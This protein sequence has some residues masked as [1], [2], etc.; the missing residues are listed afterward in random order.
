MS[1]VSPL[2]QTAVAKP[3]LVGDLYQSYVAWCRS[4]GLQPFDM[5]EFGDQ[6]KDATDA[7]GIR[8]R[9]HRDK[10][11]LVGVELRAA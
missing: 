9:A 5:I 1:P 6:L 4:S 8:T 2:A 3:G 11:F 7:V 10:V